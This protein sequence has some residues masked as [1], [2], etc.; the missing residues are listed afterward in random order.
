MVDELS[1]DRFHEQAE[2]IY[3][4]A[5]DLQFNGERTQYAYSPAL[6][7][8]ALRSEIPE[9][10]EAVRFRTYGTQLLR[11]EGTV[12]N[13]REEDITY[14]DHELFDVFTIPILKGDPQTVLTAPNTLVLTTSAAER[15]FGN[16]NPVGES[17]IVNDDATFR[18][19]GVCEDLPDNSHFQY[20]VFLSAV[21]LAELQNTMWLSN[22]VITYFLARP[23]ADL[24]TLGQK[25]NALF[26]KYAEPD[27]QKIAGTSI[28]EFEASG[29]FIRYDL[30]PLTIQSRRRT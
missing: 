29:N 18:V 5:E 20:D 12:Q 2:N 25:A 1:Y 17:M 26:R 3:C 13:I 16:A 9:V 28:A 6:L 21:D 14:V 7:A 22:N 4:V 15:Y 24:A 27:M 19:V 23:D 30:Q 10:I 11:R 8:D